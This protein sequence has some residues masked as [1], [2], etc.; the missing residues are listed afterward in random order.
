MNLII[1][2][3][4]GAIV[5]YIASWIMNTS[6]QQGPLGAVVL[7]ALYKAVTRRA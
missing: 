1:Y 3:I 5:G 6:S 2:L 4:A 7:P